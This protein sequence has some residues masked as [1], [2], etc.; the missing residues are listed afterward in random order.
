[1][2]SLSVQLSLIGMLLLVMGA[3]LLGVSSVRAIEPS[4]GYWFIETLTLGDVELPAGVV[5]RA[6]DPKVQPRGFLAL[7]NQTKNLLYVLSLGYKDVLVMKTPDPNYKNRV[8]GAHEVASYLVAPD[9]PANL[10]MEALTDLDRD[11]EDKNVSSI[12]P[13]PV[14]VPI[15]ATQSSELLLVHGDQVLIIPFTVSYALNTYYDNGSEADQ[16][17]IAN[18][19]ATDI[20]TATQEAGTPDAL[21]MKNKVITIGLVGV[22]ILIITGWWA[23]RRLSH[24]G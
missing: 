13:P 11:L 24:R 19:Q 5:I 15:P 22:I 9:R 10:G 4:K 20:A 14:N 2:K 1:M 3:M 12:N 23:W 17:R 16:T 18:T 7:E 6:S 21:G 8:N